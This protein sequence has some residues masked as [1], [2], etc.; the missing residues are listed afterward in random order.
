M[1][2]ILS[3][4]L[5][6]LFSVV[7]VGDAEARKHKSQN[8]TASHTEQYKRTHMQGM[9]YTT[10][11]G[12]GYVEKTTYSKKTSYKKS[13]HKK[14]YSKT[15]NK[16]YSSYKKKNHRYAGGGNWS[17]PR[18]WCGWWARTQLGGGPEYNRA[19]NWSK[20]GNHS[21]RPVVGAVVVWPHHVGIITGRASN[22][23][24]IVKSGN[25]G[26]RVRERA[27][28]VRGAVFRVNV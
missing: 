8:N 24:W 1:R 26:G 14:S 18:K 21:S 3:L 22:G 19:W 17:K 27:R 12:S 15:S 13:A 20:R 2:T 11:E 9:Y 23:Q 25:D 28:S 4:L 10:Y 6:A 16:K 7:S 5:I